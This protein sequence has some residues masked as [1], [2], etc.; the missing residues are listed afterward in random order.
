MI[1]P[2]FES[3]VYVNFP[4]LKSDGYYFKECLIL[5][6]EMGFHN[7]VLN[8]DNALFILS[9]HIKKDKKNNLIADFS[10]E[11]THCSRDIFYDEAPNVLNK[12]VSFTQ[13]LM[14]HDGQI[15]Q[16]NKEYKMRKIIK[17]SDFRQFQD[18]SSVLN[19]LIVDFEKKYLLLEKYLNKHHVIYNRNDFEKFI[20]RGRNMVHGFYSQSYL[21]MRLFDHFEGLDTYF[22]NEYLE[23]KVSEKKEV[24]KSIKI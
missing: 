16:K 18:F 19:S 21:K 7:Q 3:R 13:N 4:R 10:H 5:G 17:K 24:S 20:D 22:F 12:K 11:H 8:E 6:L 1:G 14:T 2:K 9:I 23:N 15:F